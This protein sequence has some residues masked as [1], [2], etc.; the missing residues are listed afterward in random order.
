MHTS[1]FTAALLLACAAG[2]AAAATH[3]I[4]IKVGDGTSTIAYDIN[5]SG[6]VAADL[7]DDD[8]REHAVLF[9]RGVLTELGTLGGGFSNSKAIN[10]KGVIVGS[11]QNK[12]GRWRAFSYSIADGM[13]DLGTLGG[14]S[15]YGLAINAAGHIAGFADTEDGY[16]RAFRYRDGAM[17]DIGP[18][19]GRFSSASGINDKGQVVG[20]AETREGYRHAFVYDE[21]HG[22]RD[23]GTLGGRQSSASAINDAG[24][25]AG[26]SET[27]NRRWH[28]FVIENG[29]MIDLGAK[30]GF[31]NSFATSI[32]SAGHVVG[33][34][35]R[36][37]EHMSFVWRDGRMLVHPGGYGLYLTNSINEAEQVVGAVKARHLIASTMSSSSIPVVASNGLHQLYGLAALMAVSAGVLMAARRRY[38]GITLRSFTF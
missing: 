10:D 25:V 33:T 26:V 15:S 30:I 16:Y 5:A 23:L 31:G 18:L 6:Q 22:M 36:G 37:E 19:G 32:N 1:S 27:K 11:A 12:A 38:R 35:I 3:P 34:V 20:T 14:P 2:S 28:A 17:Q 21:E 29:K 9:H 4:G 24:T 8:G 13:R 7:R